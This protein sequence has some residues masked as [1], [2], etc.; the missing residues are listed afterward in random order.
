L[1]IPAG[2]LS[3]IKST[4]MKIQLLQAGGGTEIFKGLEMGFSQVSQFRSN[5]RVNHV[6]LI[7]DGRTYGDEASCD[8]L[9]D[10][11]SALG[12]SISALGIGTQ[13]NDKFLDHLTSKTEDL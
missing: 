6:I 11:S 8:Q 3:D 10:Q 9:A 1:L 4:E 5:N 7:T 12:I 2:T 13:W